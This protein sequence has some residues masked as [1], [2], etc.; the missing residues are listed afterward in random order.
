VTDHGEEASRRGDIR[1]DFSYAKAISKKE[2][3]QLLFVFL[4]CRRT[5]ELEQ[6]Q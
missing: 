5:M 4:A 3:Y 1:T 2:R 6:E